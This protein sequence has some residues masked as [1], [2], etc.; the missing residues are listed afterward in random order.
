M[1]DLAVRGRA[2]AWY[3]DPV[4]AIDPHR[5]AVTVRT[6]SGASIE[7][8]AVVITVGPWAGARFA[9]ELRAY[10]SP[11]RV[12]IYWFAPRAAQREAF[13]HER[14][15]VFLYECHDGSLL[16]GIGTGASAERGVKIGFHNR[17]H[18]AAAP[19]S[20]A[21]AVTDSH[22][23][24]IARSVAQI[25][26]GL[27]PEPI[28]A[29]WCFYTMSRDESFAIGATAQDPRVVYASAC[30]GHGFKFATAVGEVLAHLAQQRPPP[31]DLRS[32]GVERFARSGG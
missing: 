14:F 17:Q 21:P 10:L 29:R 2:T 1:L 6:R 16:Y 11:E 13:E 26:P 12:P 19:D 4:E 15:P 24:E 25:F 3:G 7:A 32:F 20:P 31:V 8:G 9:P 23:R 28:D 30:S 22:R 5:G 27:D 18:T